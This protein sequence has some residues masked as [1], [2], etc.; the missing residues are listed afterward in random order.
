VLKFRLV[1]SRSTADRRDAA[2]SL[3]GA[4]ELTHVRRAARIGVALLLAVLC[5]G[6]AAAAQGVDVIRG[7]VTGPDNGPLSGARV[8]ATSVNGGVNRTARSD[9]DGRFTITFPGGEGDYFMSFTA[10]GYAPKQFE[11]KRLADEDILLAD[12]QMSRAVAALDT[13]RVTDRD[14]VSRDASKQPD[15][16]GTEQTISSDAVAASQQGDLNAMAATIPGIS[17][18]LGADGDPTGFSVLGLSPDQNSTTLNG[19]AFNTGDLPRD[20]NVSYT[21]V[22]APYDVSRGGFSGGQLNIQSGSGSNYISRSA[23]LTLDAP[24]LQWTDAAARAL[25]QQYTNVSLG[26]ALAGPIV[27]D[28]A[29]YNVS[30]QLGRRSSD[31]RSLLNTNDTGLEASGI[32]PDSARRLISLLDGAG[33]PVMVNGRVPGSRTTDSG[34]LFGTLNF[35]PPNSTTGQTFSATFSSNWNRQTPAGQSATEVPAHE[36]D[37]TRLSGGLQLNHTVYVHKILS[38][39]TVGV[40]GSRSYGTPYLSLP[41]ATVLVNSI[42]ADGSGGVSSVGFGGSPSLSTRSGSLELSADNEL[43]W[44]S[45]DNKHRLKLATEL[46]RDGYDQDETSNL[47]GSYYYNSLSD[48]EA[49][50]PASFTRSLMPRVQS[51]SQLTAAMSLGDSYRRTPALQIQYGLRLEGNRFSSAPQFNPAVQQIFGVRNDEKP[52]HVYLSPRVGFSWTYGTAPQIAAFQGAARGAR[53]VVRGGIGVFQNSPNAS[54]LGTAIDNTGLAGA[55]QQL[56]CVGSATPI[57]DWPA[58]AEDP[59]NIPLECADGSTGSVFASTAPNVVLFAKDFTPQRSVRSNLQWNGPI[60]S[61]RFS[62]SAGLTYSRNLNGSSSVDLNFNPVTRFDLADEGG[63]PVYVQ[64]GSIVPS[65]GAIAVGDARVSPLFNRV[66]E[67][68]SDMKGDTKQ[69]SLSLSPVKF[70]QNLSWSLSYVYSDSREQ[71]RGFN[72]TGGNPLD[73]QWGRGAYDTRHQITYTLRYNFLDAVRI[74]WFGRFSSGAAFTP[75]VSG[76][77]NGDGYANDRA[78]IF[79][80]SAAA[81]PAVAS[82][83]QSLLRNGSGAARECLSTQLGRIAGYNSCQGPW[84]SS[85]NLSI[86]INSLKFRLPQRA[87]L[88]FSVNNPLGAADILFHG[89][90]NLHGWGQYAS[91]DPTLLYVRGFDPV[92]S[93][94]TYDV[95]PRFGSTNPQFQRFRSPV[96]IT[97]ALRIDV[98]PS[99]ERQTLTQQLD[100]GRSHEGPKLAEPMLRALYGNGGVLN[101]M[102]Q[103]LRQSDTLQLTG[104]QADSLATMN[105]RYTI[106]LDSIWS[107]VATYWS[108]LPKDYDQGDAYRRYKHARESTVDLLIALAPRINRILSDEQKRLLPPLVASH[109]D[110]RYLRGIRSGT[111][112]GS[113]GGAFT[114]SGG[115][116]RASFT[117]VSF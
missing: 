17:A 104:P 50:A 22:T 32:A 30:Y 28:K 29:F 98:G 71:F 65:T 75:G 47:L 56:N 3:R 99:R 68:L 114:S 10:I 41:S 26:G 7:Q 93:R 84:R 110:V 74:S 46:Q 77:V 61:N 88:S 37:R 33:I 57:P 51:A 52:Q 102:A 40:N 59:A 16:S 39:T 20:A 97:M 94:F 105:R 15:I 89:E 63:R 13:V 90:N 83:M 21:V 60:L 11:L 66:T 27:F 72:S 34:R 92:H 45:K 25:G 81:D 78:F 79:D 6:I 67:E 82:A 54:L 103:M 8:M 19:S 86:A 117:T 36:G 18:V 95:N 14:R 85:A 62:L 113:G 43:S 106:E 115:G 38:E 44:F 5:S 48:L 64:P 12:A 101:P 76:D 111:A 31:L 116:A 23:S 9:A 35:T 109:L 100:R 70:S 55:V 4:G 87:T 2:R 73:V 1:A 42:F 112:G 91:P 58:Y 53:A 49:D 24:P 96:T 108:S 80:P 107:P 69:L